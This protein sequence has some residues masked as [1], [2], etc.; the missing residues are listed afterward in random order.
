MKILIRNGTIVNAENSIAADVLTRDHKIL[1]IGKDIEK[2]VRVDKIIDAA[3]C[4]LFPGAIDP[5]VHLN[6]NS[7]AGFSSDD[8]VT[9]TKAA[10]FGG[11]TSIIDFVT[12]QRGQSLVDAFF[13]RKTEAIKSL[14]DF[15]LHLTPVEQLI[16]THSEIERCFKEEGVNSFKVYMAYRKTIGMNDG[17]IFKVMK[18]VG[19]HGGIVC[20]HCEMGDE[21]DLMR[22]NFAS[23]GFSGVRYHALSRPPE[24]EFL[25]VKRAITIAEKAECPIYI[26][27]VST[28][29]S[30][31]YIREAQAKMQPV[32]AETCPH[33]LFFD[34]SRYE[35]DFEIAASYV[36]SPP[37]R[38]NK[39]IDALWNALADGTI[40]SIGT[41]HCPFKSVQKAEGK[42]DFRKIPSG[43]GGIEHRL[44][45]LYTYGV[46]NKKIGINRFVELVS[47]GP[48]KIFGMY[49]RKGIIAKD[50]DAD[51]VVW[52]PEAEGTISAKTH[53]Q[54]C[55]T[56][57][58][59]GFKT[60]G[61]A[62]H[63]ILRGK[64]VI[65]DGIMIKEPKGIYLF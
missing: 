37:L 15:K 31:D 43:V 29:E 22:D 11:T 21:I 60:K 65:E 28:K 9:G 40:Q 27:H 50:A 17:S 45:M 44:E 39:D 32:F 54:Y 30:I 36:M 13:D 18:T 6:L 3:G 49:H 1:L 58:Y 64:H 34:K 62:K 61:K 38:D 52:D 53:H 5:H 20:I 41:D 48:A 42:T 59:E 56:N 57:I 14:T 4:F 35:E 55:D 2:Q 46:L 63:V 25:A 12:P 23:K 26:V 19:R 24:M 10:L 51:I 7:E 8:F 47:S 16:H 33:Y